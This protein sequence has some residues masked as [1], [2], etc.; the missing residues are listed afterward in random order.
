MFN[1]HTQDHGAVPT[2]LRSKRVE[3][4]RVGTA[5]IAREDGRERLMLRVFAHPPES[6]PTL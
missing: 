3:R 1:K 5:R 6:Y 4:E 2:R